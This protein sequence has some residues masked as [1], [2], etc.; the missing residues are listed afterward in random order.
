[1][2]EYQNIKSTNRERKYSQETPCTL[3]QDKQEECCV[4]A[5]V[6]N[7]CMR[8]HRILKSQRQRGIRYPEYRE[9]ERESTIKSI[10]KDVPAG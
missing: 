9:Y 10:K 6:H 8:K 1:V 4:I 3:P 7:E 2:G 5:N